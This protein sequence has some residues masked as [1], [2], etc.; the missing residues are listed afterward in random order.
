M[1]LDILILADNRIR[2]TT[3][4][5]MVLDCNFVVW[6][7]CLVV[8]YLIFAY[9]ITSRCLLHHASLTHVVLE[10]NMFYHGLCYIMYF[11]KKRLKNNVI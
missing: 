3:L 11:C 4:Y 5:L 9:H 2:H 10:H 1:I 8:S 7:M 6:S